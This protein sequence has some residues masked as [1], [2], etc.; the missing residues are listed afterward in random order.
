MI[1]Y[2]FIVRDREQNHIMGVYAT[3]GLAT[4]SLCNHAKSVADDPN[5]AEELAMICWDWEIIKEIV[6]HTL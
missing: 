6:K 3:D 4:Q 2:V 5:N 1:T